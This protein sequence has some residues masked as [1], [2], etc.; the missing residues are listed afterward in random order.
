M[1]GP[2]VGL[3]HQKWKAV[4]LRRT[5]VTERRLKQHNRFI[6][7]RCSMSGEVDRNPCRHQDDRNSTNP[8]SSSFGFFVASLEAHPPI[9]RTPLTATGKWKASMSLPTSLRNI[10]RVCL[11]YPAWIRDAALWN[12]LK[13][14]YGR[15]AFTVETEGKRHQPPLF[16][17][18]RYARIDTNTML[19]LCNTPISRIYKDQRKPPF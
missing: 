7:G 16:D 4:W 17:H 10:W 6:R 13:E 14:L 1:L 19:Y 18:H 8:E 3:A 9:L 15:Y 11:S 12:T 5:F 2:F